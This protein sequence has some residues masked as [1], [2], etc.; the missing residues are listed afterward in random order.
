MSL[1]ANN[2]K[3]TYLHI[4]SLRFLQGNRNL[5]FFRSNLENRN[6]KISISDISFDFGEDGKEK[7]ASDRSS[8]GFRSQSKARSF[9]GTLWYSISPSFPFPRVSKFLRFSQKKYAFQ[10]GPKTRTLFRNLILRYLVLSFFV[11]FKLQTLLK[12]I[13]DCDLGGSQEKCVV[14]F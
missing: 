2:T 1:F 11:L 9:H 10:G 13:V 7:R 5:V 6:L 3:G 8:N 14:L 4:I 12:L